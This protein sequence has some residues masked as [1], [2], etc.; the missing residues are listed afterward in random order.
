M[1]VGTARIILY[2]PENYSLKDKRQ[3][4]K[5]LL[6]RVTNQFNVAAAEVG[7]HDQWTRAEV[8]I[9]CVTTDTRHA[10]EM[11]SRIVSFFETNLQ[12]GYIED[13]ELEII[14]IS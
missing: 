8:G 7:L 9:A 13:Y 5:S 12:Q 1:I 10:N 3:D 6:S 2:L 4:L 14:H 11:L